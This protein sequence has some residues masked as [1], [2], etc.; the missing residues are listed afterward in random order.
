MEWETQGE[1]THTAENPYCGDASCWCHT[2]LTYHGAV[3]HPA[4]QDGEVEQAYDF[5]ELVYEGR[6]YAW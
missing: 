2:D 1:A 4:Y 5:F 6:E 3:E